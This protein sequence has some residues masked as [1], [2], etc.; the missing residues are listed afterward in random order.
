MTPD[1]PVHR[2]RITKK[3]RAG[4]GVAACWCW[5]RTGL[6]FLLIKAPKSSIRCQR[7]HAILPGAAL[8]LLLVAGLIWLAMTLV[9][10]RWCG[11][12]VLAGLIARTTQYRRRAR[13]SRSSLFPLR[14][15]LA[16][17]S[18]CGNQ[19]RVSPACSGQYAGVDNATLL[20]ASSALLQ[21]FRHGAGRIA[22]PVLGPVLDPA[23]RH[24]AGKAGACAGQGVSAGSTQSGSPDFRRS[25]P[26]LLSG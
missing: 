16:D 21:Q 4:I 6:A 23:S 20:L 1:G 19:C 12:N 13:S 10:Y 7:R 22:S 5:R 18:R 25:V 24:G 2:I 17:W 8:G 14:K 9:V 3:P 26:C 15:R 11:R